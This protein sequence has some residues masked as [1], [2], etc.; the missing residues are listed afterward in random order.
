MAEEIT[1]TADVCTK[2]PRGKK[3]SYAQRL[4][5]V[6]AVNDRKN[7][8]FGVFSPSVTNADKDEMWQEVS[9]WYA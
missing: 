8:L 2:R 7:V 6:R 5:L 1:E 4:A 9:E 3:F